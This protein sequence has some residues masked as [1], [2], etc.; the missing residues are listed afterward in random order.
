[1]IPTVTAKRLFR[2]LSLIV[3][4]S[5]VALSLIAA[6]RPSSGAPL[7][8]DAPPPTGPQQSRTG[9]TP[10][11]AV[12]KRDAQKPETQKP[13]ARAQ[14][15]LTAVTLPV[16]A[17]SWR[18]G[19]GPTAVGMVV[20]Y[21]DGLGYGDLIPG[22]AAV[23]TTA[24]DQAIASGGDYVNPYPAG[25][26]Q[27]YE[28]Y[29]SPQDY[30][31]TGMMDDAYITAGRT[32]HA[33]NCIADYMH[34]SKSTSNN[35][36]G[37]SWSNH[38]APAFEAYVM[39]QNAQYETSTQFYYGSFGLTWAVLTGEID[40]G[41]PMV[42]LVDTDGDGGTDHFVTVIGYRTSPTYQYA[43]WDTWSTTTIRWEDFSF[44]ASG[45]PWGIWGGWALT[46]KAD[47]TVES[48]G[49]GTGTVTSIPAGIDC[50]ATCQA[51]V[52]FGT[53]VTLTAQA[54]A[55]STF[56]GWTGACT[57]AQPDCLVTMHGP[58]AVTA[59]F[60]TTVPSYALEII[61]EGVGSGNVT[62]VPEGI[63]CGTLCTNTFYTNTVVTLTATADPGS[64]FAGWSGA[65]V[66][67]EAD[68][69]ITMAG[70][71]QATA[72]FDSHRIYVPL[73]LRASQSIASLPQ[74]SPLPFRWKLW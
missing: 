4:L 54:G 24:V 55:E 62:S 29:A 37:W 46:V 43:S 31:S 11:E 59:T 12:L 64:I 70:A 21:Y 1:M 48:D 66:H 72:S 35:Y 67:T 18:H 73:I 6:P 19:C 23:Q 53:V 34:T 40:A 10:P 52:N 49:N 38:I 28:D 58:K 14:D 45:V 61:K 16:P 25:S 15:A 51:S 9:P 32:P 39:Q 42:F 60:T 13:E 17:Y 33:D 2:A 8:Q 7:T 27:H 44:I 3:T 57:H 47:L 69:V 68:C 74:H 50:G 26:E 65:C 20:G 30:T 71:T 36:Y 41:R 22:S 63:D 5:I 56:T